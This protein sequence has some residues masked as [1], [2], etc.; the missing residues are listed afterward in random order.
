MYAAVAPITASWSS[1]IFA[2]DIAGWTIETPNLKSAYR[3]IF[4]RLTKSS[5]E[6]FSI[7]EVF[8]FLS[9]S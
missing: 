6:P 7:R 5:N 2:L 1:E 9:L 3:D 4:A 8:P